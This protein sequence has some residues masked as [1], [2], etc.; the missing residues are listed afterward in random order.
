M[1][2]TGT[3]LAYQSNFQ[4]VLH[5]SP[6]V[7]RTCKAIQFSGD[8]DKPGLVSAAAFGLVAR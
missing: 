6:S 1:L 3:L 8:D 5:D 4:D 7:R 2:L